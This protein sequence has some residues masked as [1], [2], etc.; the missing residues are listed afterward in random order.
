M[1]E[2][3]SPRWDLKL[4]P[5]AFWVSALPFRPLRLLLSHSSHPRAYY[6][7]WAATAVI[8]CLGKDLCRLHTTPPHDS[9]RNSNNF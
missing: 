1:T 4:T 8:Y 9:A 2:K 5:L 3:F 6:F 7:A